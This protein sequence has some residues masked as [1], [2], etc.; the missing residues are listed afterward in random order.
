MQDRVANAGNWNDNI[1]L[2]VK[3]MARKGFTLIEL[4]VVI[5]IIALLLAILMPGLQRARKQARAVACLA[6]LRQWGVVF[7]MYAQDNGDKFYRA[8]TSSDVGHEWVG[9]TRPYYQ[10]PKICF[11][12]EA[13]KVVSEQAGGI[14]GAHHGLGIPM[15]FSLD[16]QHTETRFIAVEGYTFDEAA[17]LLDGSG[18]LVTIRLPF[19]GGCHACQCTGIRGSVKMALPLRQRTDGWTHWNR[20]PYLG[21]MGRVPLQECNL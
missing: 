2:Q 20:M 1:S 16:L 11:C 6:N 4:L 17:E 18:R 9:C 14:Q 21:I 19:H 5:A 12:P 7:L 10:D 3:N 8:W 15:S 13:S